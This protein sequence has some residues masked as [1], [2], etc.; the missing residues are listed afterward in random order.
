EVAF[1]NSDDQ[2]I[3]IVI[4]DKVTSEKVK[5]ALKEALGLR[6]KL[7]ET[8]REIQQQERQLKVI[9]DDQQRLRANLREMPPTAEAYKRYLKKFA[10][11]E[12]VIE[13]YQEK[14]KQLQDGEHAQRKA[15]ESSLAN[16]NAE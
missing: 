9:T 2:S 5:A 15:N 1:T 12:T 13:K 4:D 8:T 16:L 3:R 11:Q 6:W 7:A 14:I 10:Q